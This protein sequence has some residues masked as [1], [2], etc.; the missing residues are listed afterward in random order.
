MATKSKSKPATK[1]SLKAL[2]N[3][4]TKPVVKK[5][6]PA[7]EPKVKKEQKVEP[8][9]LDDVKLAVADREHLVE[10]CI[11]YIYANRIISNYEK[12]RKALS[13]K[14]KEEAKRLKLPPSVFND[15]FKLTVTKSE[16]KSIQATLLLSLGVSNAI[17][18]K[19][20]KTTPKVTLKVTAASG[21]GDEGGEE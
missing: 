2:S 7:K 9:P 17:I 4:R 20:T 8:V 6:A 5:A 16:T 3:A 12:E 19:A 10:L 18:E 13:A 14:I 1:K 21:D 15:E 11:D